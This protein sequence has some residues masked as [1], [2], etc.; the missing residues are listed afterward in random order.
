MRPQARP[1]M[2]GGTFRDAPLTMRG[3]QCIQQDRLN[4]Q[5]RPSV[6]SSSKRLKVVRYPAGFFWFTAHRLVSRFSSLWLLA[7]VQGTRQVDIKELV[8]PILRPA[9]RKSGNC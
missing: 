5:P 8:R 9:F 6:L 1:A 3:F 4:L 2:K 7:P